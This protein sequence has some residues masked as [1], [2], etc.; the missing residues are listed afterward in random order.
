MITITEPGAF[1]TQ[2]V[3]REPVEV[4]A[5]AQGVTFSECRFVS[6]GTWEQAL[7]AAGPGTR[8]LGCELFGDYTLGHRRGIMVNAPNIVIDTLTAYNLH[9]QDDAWTIAGW[10]GTAHLEVRNCQLEASGETIIFGGAHTSSPDR[11]PQDILIENCT[12]VKPSDWKT[13]GNCTVKNL[14]EI[15]C[16][17][18]IT[19]RNVRMFGCWPDGQGGYAIVVTVRAKSMTTEPDA[20]WVCIEDVTFSGIMSRETACG[21]QI[22]GHDQYANAGLRRLTFEDSRFQLN[23]PDGKLI[24]IGGGAEDVTIR[25]SH[26][27]ANA[28]NNSWLTFHDDPLVRFRMA[29]CDLNEGYYGARGD[30]CAPGIDSITT[31]APDAVFENVVLW[32]HPGASFTY[33][34]GITAE[35]WGKARQARIYKRGCA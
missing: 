31:Y 33:P 20:P 16:G 26:F 11:I 23:Q 18:R 32:G 29:D 8:V 25:R 13:I 27:W 19:V 5:T 24:Q 6:D 28:D 2:Q 34:E 17:K 3:F 21:L 15:K 4:A 22:D 14:F 10:D 1:L 35:R 30:N 9:H 12:F 7:L